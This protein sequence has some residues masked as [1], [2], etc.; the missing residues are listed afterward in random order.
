MT[1]SP[2]AA[3]SLTKERAVG[4]PFLAR[5]GGVTPLPLHGFCGAN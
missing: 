1:T 3:C 4:N 2:I 5:A